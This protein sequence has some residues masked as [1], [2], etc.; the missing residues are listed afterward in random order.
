MERDL[1]RYYLSSL[2]HVQRLIASNKLSRIW[3]FLRPLASDNG[4]LIGLLT[5][6][7][8]MTLCYSVRKEWCYRAWVTDWNWTMFWVGL[9][10][11][12]EKQKVHENV[13]ATVRISDCDRSQ[14]TGECRIFQLFV[15]LRN[16][17]CKDTHGKLNV[18][19]KAAFKKRALLA[20]NWP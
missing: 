13:K 7:N 11:N 12:V 19:A 16:K 6:P 14:T 9:E 20:A 10:V 3:S 15:Q 1:L 8:Q 17:W 4:I 2:T 5:L 18:L